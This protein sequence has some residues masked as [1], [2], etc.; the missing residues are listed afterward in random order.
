V[1]VVRDDIARHVSAAFIGGAATGADLI[2]LAEAGHAWHDVV[3]V[4]RGLPEQR[5]GHLYEV[6]DHLAA[7]R[8]TSTPAGVTALPD[9][10]S[11]VTPASGTHGSDWSARIDLPPS[12]TSP[13]A[14]RALLR[15]AMQEW[16]VGDVDDLDLLLTEVVTNAVVHAGTPFTLHVN[17]RPGW[18]RVEVHDSASQPPDHR[19]ANRRS[20][21]GR[22]LLLRNCSPA[23]AR[24][25]GVSA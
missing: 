22:G 23:S 9:C 17:G 5:F 18:V 8:P 1:P 11:P 24:L 12:L 13:R 15:V 19:R 3:S 6:W 25:I 21:H 7:P 16:E 14:A 4:L 10:G 20:E 2:A